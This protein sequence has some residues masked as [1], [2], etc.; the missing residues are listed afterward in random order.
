[1]AFLLNASSQSPRIVIVGGGVIG[2]S[3][4]WRLARENSGHRILLLDAHRAGEGT[5]RVSAGMIAPIAEAGFEDPCFIQF[6]RLSRER[7]RS[8]VSDVSIDAGSPVV[9]GEEGS[10]I[11]S[12]HRTTWMRCGACTSIVA[13]RTF[14]WNG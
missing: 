6:A 1:V 8:F 4:A 10:I 11:V 9:L 14:R 13:T 7:Y 5:S 2:L 12:I 3:I